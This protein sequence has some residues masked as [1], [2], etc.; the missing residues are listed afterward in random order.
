MMALN[1]VHIHVFTPCTTED[2]QHQATPQAD[3]P[4]SGRPNLAGMQHRSGRRIT[5]AR[6]PR[7]GRCGC[8][9]SRKAP[10]PL[11]YPAC[12]QP[13]HQESRN[14]F[15]IKRSWPGRAGTSVLTR[16]SFSMRRPF[17][18]TYTPECRRGGG[19]LF[20]WWLILQTPGA[21]AMGLSLDHLVHRSSHPQKSRWPR[22]LAR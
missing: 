20:I 18:V 7:S 10:C 1:H 13:R 8:R 6:P 22:G 5:A 15:R 17:V 9:T 14:R 16:S 2:F 4:M 12:H 3:V 21:G 19:R 11:P